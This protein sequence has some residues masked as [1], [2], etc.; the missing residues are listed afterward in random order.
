MRRCLQSEQTFVLP[1]GIVSGAVVRNRTERAAEEG[2]LIP[3]L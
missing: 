1:V 3:S 2:T